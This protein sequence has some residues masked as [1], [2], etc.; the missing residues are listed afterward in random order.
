MALTRRGD[1]SFGD[2]QADIRAELHRYSG[3]NGYLAEH[4]ADAA[5]LALP[6]VFPSQVRG[7]ICRSKSGRQGKPYPTERS[8]D[9]SRPGA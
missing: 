2:S 5:G 6:I 8:R 1:Q 4:F 3:L 7:P 9:Q